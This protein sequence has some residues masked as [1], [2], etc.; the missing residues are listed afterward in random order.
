MADYVLQQPKSP[1][2][3]WKPHD[4]EALSSTALA[5]LGMGI[6]ID[7]TQLGLSPSKK[8][9]AFLAHQGVRRG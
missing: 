6:W 5:T 2:S 9:Q 8:H 4:S 3:I 1:L 7:L